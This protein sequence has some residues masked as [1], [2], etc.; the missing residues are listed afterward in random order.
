MRKRT[1]DWR[2]ILSAYELAIDWNRL[3]VGFVGTVLT[4]IVMA[5]VAGLYSFLAGK[6]V[7]KPASEDLTLLG[8]FTGD[9]SVVLSLVLGC[10]MRMLKTFA[11]LL[12]PLAA[13]FGHLLLSVLTYAALFLVWSTVGG[14][15]S[16]LAVLEYARDDLPTVGEARQ[17]V[18]AR[19]G[20]YLMAL[21]WPLIVIA[22][23]AL[24]NA[25]GGLV[26]SAWWPGR[27]L[28]VLGTLPLVFSTAA[29]LFVAVT[30]VL[31][32][33]MIV[34]G[35]STTGRGGLEGWV[36][37]CSYVLYGFRR[38]ICYTVLA[39]AIGAL[40]SV[41]VWAL[42]ELMIYLIRLTVNVGFIHPVDWI[43][44]G[45][46]GYPRALVP[47]EHGGAFYGILSG[48][49]VAILM[50]VRSAPAAFAFSYFFTAGTIVYLLM[51]KEVDNVAIEEV[52]EEEEEEEAL[53][54]PF[55]EEAPQEAEAPKE[56]AGEARATE[57]PAPQPEAPEESTE[58]QPPAPGEQE[59]APAE[60]ESAPPDQN[61]APEEGEGRQAES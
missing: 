22:I 29:I 21:Y 46:P 52:Y 61:A 57:A 58:Q 40:A 20:A 56:E 23:C 1:G 12:N 55:A 37:A 53:A 35:V 44:Y 34:P 8:Q 18:R 27:I 59:Q 33:S 48:I 39:L 5:V 25:I 36:A 19:R 28:L 16:R 31:G 30:T 7:I 47:T 50:V 6:H 9:S 51:R 14:V 43:Q 49:I 15:I 45:M 26:A 32:F 17:F 38:L 41:A 3:Y 4:V 54:E 11:L 42:A 10:G 13:G 24:M 60:G 2:D